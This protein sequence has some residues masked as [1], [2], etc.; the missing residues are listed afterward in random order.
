M[1]AAAG[2]DVVAGLTSALAHLSNGLGVEV[3]LE[4]SQDPVTR[5]SSK[6]GQGVLCI[7]L[8]PVPPM[9]TVALSAFADGVCAA[10]SARSAHAVRTDTVLAKLSRRDHLVR[11]LFDLSPIGILLIDRDTGTILE[12]NTAFLG[13]GGWPRDAVVGQDIVALLPEMDRHVHGQALAQMEEAD[14][15]GPIEHAFQRPDG[16]EFPAVVRGLLIEQG[17]GRRVVWVLVEDLSLRQAHLAEIRDARDE[18]LRAQSELDTAV[19][20][21]PHGFVLFDAQDRVVM[22]NDQMQVVCPELAPFFRPGRVYGD[23][24]RDATEQGVFPEAR[25]REAAFVD[26]ILAARRNPVFQRLITLSSGRIL[27]VLDSAT[28]DGGRVGLRID[29]TA[30]HQVARRLGDVILGSQAGTWEVDLITGENI[31]NDRWYE[32]LGLVRDDMETLSTEA[33]ALL[34]HP[35]DRAQVLR[36]VNSLISGERAQ[37]EHSYRMRGAD[38]R[39]IWIS[40][41]GRITN[42]AADGTPTRMA[43]VHIDISAVKEAEERLEHIIEGAEVGT[44]QYDFSTGRNRINDRWAAMIGY[45]RE[46]LEPMSHHL[47]MSLVHPDD[48]AALNVRHAT[49]MAERDWLSADELRLRHKDGYWVWVLS[50]GRVTAWNEP[51]VPLV[52]SGVHVD[53]SAR[54]QLETDLETERDFLATLTETSVSGVMAVDAEA[55]IVFINPEVLAIFETS[56]ENLIGLTCDP[57][58]LGISDPVSGPMI[59]ADMPCRKALIAGSIQRDLRLRVALPGG[60]VKVV[61]VNAAPLPDT[62]T[63]A[64]VVCTITDITATAQAEDR[65]RAAIG[66]AEAASHA[67]SQFLANMSHELRTPLNGVLGMADLL[68]ESDLDATAHGMVQTIRDSGALLLSILNDI[69]DLAKIESGKL[70]LSDEVFRLTD[71]ATRMDAMHGLAARVKG[72][73]LTVALGADV[74]SLR[75]GDPQRLLQVMH[76]LL[77]NAVK[78]TEAGGVDLV[79]SAEGSDVL[80]TVRDSGIGMTPE[81]IAVVFDEFT[82]GDGSIT[83]RFGGTGLGLPIARRLV[84]LMGGQIT[85]TSAPGTGTQ[86]QVRLTLAVAAVP[87]DQKPR[88]ERPDFTGLTALV[89]EDNATN[90]VILR[91][92]LGRL[93]ISATMVQDG[94]EAVLAF[95]TGRFDLV[96]LDISMPRKDGITALAEMRVRAGKHAMPPAIAVTANAMTHLVDMYLSAGFDEVVAKPMQM[97]ALAASILRVC[98]AGAVNLASRGALSP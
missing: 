15:F 49:R 16:R 3:A 60:R 61:S 39:W 51:G 85:L 87:Q 38:G 77:G 58:L 63:E 98:P 82:Q 62:G 64:R 5:L 73:R 86:V 36:D 57:S 97:D 71:L 54:K 72:V 40:D 66:R 47:W 48:M 52:M 75:R 89:A 37:Y 80:I 50:R 33:W 92:M 6:C 8:D 91:A 42:W 14:Q 55:R 4:R 96:L 20:A 11:S 27:R 13:F 79:I 1:L 31:V 2:D 30:E 84:E 25:G 9:L 43:G 88:Q 90:R 41:R 18:A 28:P 22:V 35:D 46:E 34:I 67:K 76:N 59:L 32:M 78:F 29:V 19:Q 26:E 69:L 23:I 94:D 68:A 93:G 12:A 53:I 17:K 10:Q 56:Y 44:W 95:A 7:G 70:S 21:L 74:D 45:T 81:Q 83:R 65:L 24:L